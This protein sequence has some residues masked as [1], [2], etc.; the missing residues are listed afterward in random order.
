MVKA[1]WLTAQNTRVGWPVA[2]PLAARERLI[3]GGAQPSVARSEFTD[4]EDGLGD[5]RM[6]LTTPPTPRSDT[7]QNVMGPTTERPRTLTPRSRAWRWIRLTLLGMPFL[8]LTMLF[9]A[10]WLFPGPPVGN[11]T[12][13]PPSPAEV[14]DRLVG[15]VLYT[16]EARAA[17]Q[18][19]FFDFSR[20]AVVH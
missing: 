12:V 1:V 14:G 15:P 5:G 4:A 17:E 7:H 18:W 9:L 11:F 6:E 8:G 20:G 3:A 16:L 10:P 13:T 2:A 19:T